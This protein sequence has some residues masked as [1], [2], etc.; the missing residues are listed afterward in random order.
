MARIKAFEKDFAEIWEFYPRKQGKTRA[1]HHVQRLLSDYTKEQIIEATKQ[2][3]SEMHGREKKF[4]LVGSSFYCSRVLDY[5][6]DEEAPE[7][8]PIKDTKYKELLDYLRY[9]DYKEYIHSEHWAHFREQALVYANFKC[10]ICDSSKNLS[11]HH[12]TYKNRGR[13]TFNDVIVVCGECHA[14]IHGI[15]NNK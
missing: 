5:L 1:M 4:V 8:K 6:I 14:M 10:S 13:E 12:K 15:E 7:D 2:F 11:V 3:A 9:M